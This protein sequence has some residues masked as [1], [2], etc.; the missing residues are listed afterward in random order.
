MYKVHV[1]NVLLESKGP[2]Q[3]YFT[4]INEKP[5]IFSNVIKR[6]YIRRVMLYYK[7]QVRRHSFN[8]M[9]MSYWMGYCIGSR[10]I[11]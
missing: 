6:N 9:T 7:S 2:H 10:T 8:P 3:F 4:K 1:H 11:Y 5:L